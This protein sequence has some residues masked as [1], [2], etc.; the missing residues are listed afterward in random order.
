MDI[1]HPF[2]YKIAFNPQRRPFNICR[3]FTVREIL[4]HNHIIFIH[5]RNKIPAAA[6][7]INPHGLKHIIIPAIGSLNDHDHPL[8]I[9]LDVELLGTAVNIDQEQ[10]IQQ[11]ILNKIIFIKPLLVCNKKILDLES[12]HLPYHIN[13]F[14]NPCRDQDI[15]QLLFIIY[16]KILKSLNLLGIRRR[17]GKIRRF[18]RTAR[19]V[20]S[21]GRNLFAIRV[22]NAKFNPGNPLQPVNCVLQ[23][24]IRNHN[25]LLPSRK[26]LTIIQFRQ[27]FPLAKCHSD[28]LTFSF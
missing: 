22:H 2:F 15:F 24:L 3:V 27:Y 17:L 25:A 20:R 21:C 4:D 8:Y 11:Q 5:C 26:P 23:Y 16:L 10:I 12:R 18:R 1:L 28:E 14:T 7:K 13:I 9:R 19:H 6:A